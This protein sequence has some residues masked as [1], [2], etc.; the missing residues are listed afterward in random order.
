MAWVR[1]INCNAVYITSY[2]SMRIPVSIR[3]CYYEADNQKALVDS[4]ATDCFIHPRLA[5]Q[6]K[7]GTQAF[8]KPRRSLTLITSCMAIED[9]EGTTET[10]AWW[11]WNLDN[12][13]S[14]TATVLL[15]NENPTSTNFNATNSNA[16]TST[17][18]LQCHNF[19]AMS[20]VL[21]SSTSAYVSIPCLSLSYAPIVTRISTHKEAWQS[22]WTQST[23][24]KAVRLLG[25]LKCQSH[26]PSYAIPTSLVCK[27]SMQLPILFC[28]E[29]L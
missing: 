25:W 24:K 12:L 3:M 7:V 16:T 1:A 27:I 8:E 6:M 18:C 21:S 10:W 13:V 9:E 2:R 23:T 29:Y 20:S 28:A 11:F 26:T 5:E 15:T 14:C 4:G 17:P 22:M 19:N